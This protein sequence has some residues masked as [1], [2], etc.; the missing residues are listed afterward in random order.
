MGGKLPPGITM[1]KV[2]KLF[3]PFREELEK[4]LKKWGSKEMVVL[5]NIEGGKVRSIQ[6]K[7]FQGKSREKEALEKILKKL[8]FS[9]SVKGKMELELLYV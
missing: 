4:V 8:V 7:S 9:S 2:E 3:S 1:E 5:M 6:F